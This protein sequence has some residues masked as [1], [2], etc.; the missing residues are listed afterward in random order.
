MSIYIIDKEPTANSF[1]ARDQF[2]FIYILSKE[3][4]LPSN[5]TRPLYFYNQMTM[6]TP[7]YNRNDYYLDK[8]WKCYD[9]SVWIT[10]LALITFISI[11]SSELNTNQTRYQ[12]INSILSS[13][14]EYFQPLLR[15][16]SSTSKKPKNYLYCLYLFTLF[17]LIIVFENEF[18]AHL[19]SYQDV[20]LDII[21]DFI[22][23]DKIIITTG[24]SHKK[25]VENEIKKL[26][27]CENAL[28]Y[29]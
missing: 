22:S 13:F 5:C 25:Y 6:W 17:P 11:L 14:W 27:K 9:S 4:E 12:M 1:D 19:V 23:R 8:I 2:P 10:F 21:D 16:G 29:Y 26:I 15:K 3:F 24:H 7:I 28:I 18:L 20:K